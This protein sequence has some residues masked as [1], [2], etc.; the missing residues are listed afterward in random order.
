MN[1]LLGV[2]VDRKYME[3]KILPH[4]EAVI[5]ATG[6]QDAGRRVDLGV[7]SDDKG[8][9]VD[10]GSWSTDR[11]GIFAVGS[12]VRRQQMAIRTVAQG[13]AAALSVGDY[14]LG[15]EH[16]PFRKMFNSRF[17]KLQQEEHDEYLKEATPDA[18]VAPQMGVLGGFDLEEA[19]KEAARCMH[20]D[21]RK[22]RT[23]KLRLYA[24]AYGADRKKYLSGERKPV[25][26]QFTHESIV[27]EREKCI[28][29]GLCVEIT[30]GEKELTGLA[31]IGRGFDVR[32]GIPFTRELNEA[33][34]R[35]ALKCA[36]ACPTAAI[37]LKNEKD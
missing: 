13:K 32:I 14:L 30:A 5:L 6:S 37:S 35:T 11:K 34:T 8:I 21:C 1:F 26:K 24:D 29:C 2:E 4:S 22:P 33:L 25:V 23:C 18:R 9:L 15:R 12:A 7:L 10:K 17:G 36:E 3:E 28:K 20:C 27:Y 31:F 19:R 16:D